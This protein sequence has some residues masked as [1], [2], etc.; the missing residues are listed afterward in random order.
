M[1]VFKL[2]APRFVANDLNFFDFVKPLSRQASKMR[3]CNEVC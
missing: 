1:F 3:P 2:Y